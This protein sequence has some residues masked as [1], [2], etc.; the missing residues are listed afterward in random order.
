MKLLSPISIFIFFSISLFSQTPYLISYQAVACDADGNPLVNQAVAIRFSILKDSPVGSP[1]YVETHATTSTTTDAFGL[2]TIQIGNGIPVTGTPAANLKA[3]DW[4]TGNYWLKVE[5][6]PTGGANFATLGVNRLLSVP[7]AFYA[8]KAALAA[9]ADSASVAGYAVKAGSATRADTASVA[10]Y[11]IKAGSATYSDSA[12]ITSIAVTAQNAINA[13][14]AVYSDSS[15]VSGLAYNAIKAQT[16]TTA[17]SAQTAVFAD[18]TRVSGLAYNAVKAQTALFADSTR[19]AGFTTRATYADSSR[20]SGFSQTA[21]NAINAQTAQTAVTAQTATNATNAVNAQTAQTAVTAQTATNATNAV[22]AQ[23]AQTAVTAQTATNATNAVNAQTAQTAVTAQTA[24]NAT[25]AVN[26]QT[27][28]YADSTRVSKYAHTSGAAQTAV[29][30]QAATN[31]A[32]AVNAQ[33]ALFADSTRVSNFAQTAGAAQTAVNATNAITAQNAINASMAQTAV[34][35]QTALND[36]DRD[37]TNELQALQFDGTNLTLVKYNPNNPGVNPFSINLTNNFQG[38]G[39]SQDFPEGLIGRYLVINDGYTVPKDSTLYLTSGGQS[40]YLP[41]QGA[42]HPNSPTMPILPEQ[43]TVQNCKCTALLVRKTSF[44]EPVLL[45]L[46]ATS[47][48][49]YTIPAGKVFIL[50]SGIDSSNG[51]IDV[52]GPGAA[53]FDLF[54]ICN[55]PYEAATRMPTF[56]AGS[57][58]RKPGFVQT[59]VLTGYLFN[60]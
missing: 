33:T 29:T 18:S 24:T 40:I 30:A 1:L 39:A 35:A 6:D 23:T 51:R 48:N 57:T 49:E 7:Y 27:A 14:Y 19:V 28:L 9:R 45:N 20:V 22:N 2:F 11:A 60:K 25:N 53:S 16:A 3:I 47:N 56:P 4:S 5:M 43:T 36:F 31:A 13:Q 59:M 15:R 10:A 12:R 55:S 26:A 32:N 17:A 58:I 54:D 38:P 44:I 52:K 42:T 50:K 46:N 34:T 41:V 8:E 21:T 37:S